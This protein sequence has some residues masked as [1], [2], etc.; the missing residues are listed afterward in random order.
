LAADNLCCVIGRFL[1]V[2]VIAPHRRSS[3]KKANDRVTT[4]LRLRQLQQ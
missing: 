1:I 2:S 3:P 4:D